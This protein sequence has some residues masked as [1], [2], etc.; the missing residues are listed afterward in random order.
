[1]LQITELLNQFVPLQDLH[2]YSV[3]EAWLKLDG[4][5]RIFG[6]KWEIARKIKKKIL[7]KY[8]LPCSMGIGPNMFLAK[9]AMDIEGKK[10]GLVE[11]TYEDVPEKLWPVQLSECWGIGTR[12]ERRLNRI[13]VETVGEL[14]H[15]PEDYLEKRFGIM[16]TQLYNHAWGVDLSRVEGDYEPEPRNLGRGITLYSDYKSVEKIKIVIFELCEEVAKRTR[17]HNLLG[18]TISLGITYSHEELA[19]GFR[20]QR[21]LPEYT[22]LIFDIYNICLELFKE[23]YEGQVVRKV[24]VSLGNFVTDSSFQLNL[25]KDKAKKVKLARVKDYIENRYGAEAIFYGKSLKDGSIRRRIVK[26]IGG[27]KR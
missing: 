27:H 2:I 11:W 6:D 24:Q 17:E 19:G 13:G 22:N 25:F 5:E 15:L 14:A 4:V 23:N 16:G 3:D 10:K 21:T 1:S 9:V 8:S 7:K 20:V 26:N 12:L 18:K